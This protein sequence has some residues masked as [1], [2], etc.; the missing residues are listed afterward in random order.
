MTNQIELSSVIAEMREVRQRLNVASKQIFSL[1]TAKAEAERNYKVALRQE[2]LKLKSEGFPA[3]LI[4]DLAKGEERIAQL[5]LE[6]DIAKEMYLSGL[7]SMKQTRTEASVLQTVAK[8]Q[9][10]W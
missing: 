8:V 1:A 2:I 9:S 4:N 7:E 5:R 10:D 6:R 3:T